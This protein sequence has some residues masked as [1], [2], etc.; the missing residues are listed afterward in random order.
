MA[1]GPLPTL[2]HARSFLVPVL[3]SSYR[4]EQISRGR[5]PSDWGGVQALRLL[6]AQRFPPGQDDVAVAWL[7]FGGQA[8]AAGALGGDEGLP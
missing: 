7:Q 6:P 3:Q 8:G 4:S 5:C 1:A 2:T